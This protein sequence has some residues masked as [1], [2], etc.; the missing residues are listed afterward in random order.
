MKK[1]TVLSSIFTIMLLTCFSFSVQAVEKESEK[2][3]IKI[4]ADKIEEMR[5]WDNA[6]VGT[7]RVTAQT[8]EEKERFGEKY[9]T[10]VY[11]FVSPR[12]DGDDRYMVFIETTKDLNGTVYASVCTHVS[13]W[14]RSVTPCEFVPDKEIIWERS[15][16]VVAK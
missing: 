3:T 10:K 12:P 11:K 4:T 15:D 7:K 8:E 1:L 16:T 2:E 14:D 13:F 6:L 5:K 9:R